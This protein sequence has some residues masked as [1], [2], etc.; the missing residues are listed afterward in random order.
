MTARDLGVPSDQT[1]VKASM[2]TTPPPDPDDGD[3]DGISDVQEVALGTDPND[4]DTDDDGRSD[5]QETG[6]LGASTALLTGLPDPEPPDQPDPAVFEAT[7]HVRRR[8]STSWATTTRSTCPPRPPRHPRASR[9]IL[10]K[11][12]EGPGALAT[13]PAL[14]QTEWRVAP[15]EDLE[16]DRA[17][18]YDEIVLEDAPQE[19]PV[20]GGEEPDRAQPRSGAGGVV[21]L[22]ALALSP[23]ELD[24]DAGSGGSPSGGLVG[25]GLR[26]GRISGSMPGR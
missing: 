12:G 4:I 17:G 15:E 25:L 22:P 18:L 20:T 5:D 10:P 8:R 24:A 19:P 23:N 14:F 11:E 16:A 21:G 1:E 13:D 2:S 6:R 3:H 7:W 9:T 26:L